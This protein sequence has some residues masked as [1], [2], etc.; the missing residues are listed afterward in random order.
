[1][2]IKALRKQYWVAQSKQRTPFSNRA[3]ILQL[4]Q[5]IS[6]T[7]QQTAQKN[8]RG[9]LEGTKMN[10]DARELRVPGSGMTAGTDERKEGG[11][12]TGI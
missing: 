7:N 9:T 2:F 6:N 11:S 3:H 5:E 10:V 8:V 4:R 1:M 12:H